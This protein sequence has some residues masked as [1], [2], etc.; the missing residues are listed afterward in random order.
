MPELFVEAGGTIYNTL[1]ER[2]GRRV[3]GE[4][5]GRF[6]EATAAV[7][8]EFAA[9]AD[10]VL[11]HLWETH[12]NPWNGQVVNASDRLQK[13]S[14]KGIQSIMRSRLVMEGPTLNDIM[15]SMDT[16]TMTIHETGGTIAA[17]NV[18]FLTIPLPAALDRRGLPK[19]RSARD[20][21]NTFVRRSRAG[22]LIIFQRTRT[23]LVPLYLL[24]PS[25]RIPARLGMARTVEQEIPRLERGIIAALER[26]L[27][28]P[29][30]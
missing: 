18:R 30:Q 16:G 7:G 13:R 5:I 12:R 26:A 28:A 19:K 1:E 4:W 25:V 15:A 21:P 14:G 2:W 17:R 9:Y 11:K 10:R 29:T 24:K 22:N 27:G 23:G 6:D 3:A 20:W 8:K